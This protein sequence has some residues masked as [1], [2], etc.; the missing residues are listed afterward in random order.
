MDTLSEMLGVVLIMG[1]GAIFTYAI[2]STKWGKKFMEED[3][4]EEE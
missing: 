1:V 4:T 2:G 3:D